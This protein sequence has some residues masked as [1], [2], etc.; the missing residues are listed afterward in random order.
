MN[1]KKAKM[2][3]RLGKDS[4]ADKR[5][6]HKLDQASKDVINQIS[7]NAESIQLVR[8]VLATQ[9]EEEETTNV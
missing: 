2:L 6:F 3:R 7:K 8:D 1:S 5:L 4:A 9:Y